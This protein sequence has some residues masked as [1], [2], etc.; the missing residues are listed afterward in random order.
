MRELVK[1]FES[2]RYK[3]NIYNVFGDFCACAAYAISN[4]V[5]AANYD[6][7]EA[8]YMNTISKYS[9]D[10][11]TL[12]AKMLADLTVLLHESGP[13]DLLGEVFMALEITNKNT[14]QFFT[15]Q[16]VSDCMGA[17]MAHG[18]DEKI[19]EKG[20]VTLCEPA[21]GGGSTVFG[22]CKAMK[23]QGFDYK[24]QLQVT[25]VDIDLRCVHMAYVQMAL[26]EIPAVVYHG[27]ALSVETYS[28]W[29]TPAYATIKG[30]IDAI[31]EPAA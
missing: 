26:L 1:S 24:T 28:T 6:S 29:H 8:E 9:K 21:V 22:F 15:P 25:A 4:R 31:T 2:F 20:Y 18:L 3:H 7:R 19:Q 14:G 11:A 10:E 27:N 17:M 12:F 30:E 23:A 16:P 13:R 5:D